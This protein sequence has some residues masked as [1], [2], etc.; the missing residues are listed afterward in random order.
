[1]TFLSVDLPVSLVLG[2]F[3]SILNVGLRLTRSTDYSVF[4]VVKGTLTLFWVFEFCIISF[5]GPVLGLMSRILPNSFRVRCTLSV[6]CPRLRF[7]CVY[8]LNGLFRKFHR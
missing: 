3:Q 8:N 7:F 1:M 2:H 4:I 5:T 6:N